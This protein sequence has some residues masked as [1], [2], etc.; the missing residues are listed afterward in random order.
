MACDNRLACEA[1]SLYPEEA[2]FDGISLA[3]SR[4]SLTGDVAITPGGFESKSDRYRIIIDGRVADTG[5]ISVTP[6]EPIKVTGTD[7]LR[8]AR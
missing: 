2:S 8:L 6:S 3:L 1:V 5:P 7:A 4:A